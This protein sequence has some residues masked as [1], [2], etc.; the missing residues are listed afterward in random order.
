MPP[1]FVIKAHISYSGSSSICFKCVVSIKEYDMNIA[2]VN[3]RMH[4]SYIYHMIRWN[5]DSIIES[6]LDKFS[7]SMIGLVIKTLVSQGTNIVSLYNAYAV[8]NYN[9]NACKAQSTHFHRVF[10]CSLAK[11]FQV[12][13]SKDINSRIHLSVLHFDRKKD[14]HQASMLA[15][16]KTWHCVK[17]VSWAN[18]RR[19]QRAHC[20]ID[21]LPSTYFSVCSQN[22]LQPPP[23]WCVKASI[24]SPSSIPSYTFKSR[25]EMRIA[26]LNKW[27]Y[28]Y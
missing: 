13:T 24:S 14:H 17:F 19:K 2:Y 7:G 22:A 23:I 18:S 4:K 15:K 10:N 9:P 16:F 8:S 27:Y 12:S 11:C 21:L 20:L 28:I 5:H 3:W 25:P 26:I 6:W 1:Y